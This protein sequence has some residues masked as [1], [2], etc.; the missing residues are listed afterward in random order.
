MFLAWI[1]YFGYR[2]CENG[3]ATKSTI[4]PNYTQ[5]DAWECFVAF[6][7][8]FGRQTLQNLC[9]GRNSL[10]QGTELAKMVLQRNQPFYLIK[11]QTMFQSVSDHYAILWNIK[12]C[13]TWVSSLNA[14]FQA[15][16]LGKMV[17]QRNLPFYPIRPKMMFESVSEHFANLSGV[18]WCKTCVFGLN[19]L[20][21]GTE[22]AKIVSQ[23]NQ[24]FYLIGPQMMFQSVSEHF[25]NLWN[26]KWCKT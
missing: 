6:C 10:F 5:N 18:K 24:P 7:K 8:P 3:F 23:R 25:A 14:L 26:I 4:L 13:K 22:L 12:W 1:H 9:F 2:T 19:S 17:S 21:R 11:P 16:E 20:F 15:T